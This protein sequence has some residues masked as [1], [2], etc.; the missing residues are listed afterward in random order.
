M[1]Y[2]DE[3]KG[4]YQNRYEELVAAV[5]ETIG[6]VDADTLPKLKLIDLLMFLDSDTDVCIAIEPRAPFT[7][8][9]SISGTIAYCF[10]CLMRER[11]MY[12]KYPVHCISVID[13]GK[14]LIQVNEPENAT[15]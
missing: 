9:T 8:G 1:S 14:L 15:T 2:A 13:G 12:S 10:R 6:F 3:T 5:E 11:S 4:K 7:C